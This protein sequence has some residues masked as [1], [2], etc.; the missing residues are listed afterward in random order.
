MKINKEL[1]CQF[2]IAAQSR[3]SAVSLSE[4]FSNKPA[5][6]SFTRWLDTVKLKPK[7]LWE[8]AQDMTELKAGNLIIDDSV[9]DKFHSKKIDIAYF[10]YSGNHHRPVNGIGVINLLWNKQAEPERAEH[11]P[12]DLR[13]FDKMRDGKT[14]NE[15]CR[16]ML[17]TAYERGFRNIT[18]LM[19]SAY[20]DLKTLKL[21][22]EYEWNFITG[23]KS[24]RKV[25]LKPHEEKCVADIAAFDGIKCHLRGY[26]DV[27]VIKRVFNQDLKY[28][29]TNNLTLS[30]PVIKE[31]SD[32]RWKIEEL[33]RGEKQTTGIEKCQFRNQRAQRNHILCSTLAFLAIEKHRLETGRSW[34]E[35]KN[36]IIA[37]ALKEYLRKPFIPLPKNAL[38]H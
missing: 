5:H 38:A 7:I 26:G 6:D 36:L 31:V 1:Y 3:Y 19:D 4:L 8:Y 13:I 22:R 35:S 15:H 24:N 23:L 9:L 18:V 33:H 28:L 17:E 11:I 30:S 34:Y 37:D 2:L 27:K 14:K 16:E 12:V 25:S 20:S 10:Q 32:R 21:I 29:A